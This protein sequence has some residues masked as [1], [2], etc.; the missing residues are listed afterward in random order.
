MIGSR[1]E[2]ND[3]IYLKV[4][5]DIE[6]LNENK[7]EM[8]QYN[9]IK[10]I[11]NF[12]RQYLN[13]ACFFTYNLDTYVSLKTLEKQNGLQDHQLIEILSQINEIVDS[14]EDYFL[15]ESKD[16][17]M[18]LENIYYDF[19]KEDV[20]LI[21]LPTREGTS[22]KSQYKLFLMDLISNLPI[23]R[24]HS[25]F[26]NALQRFIQVEEFSIQGLNE[27][28]KQQIL[29]DPSKDIDEKTA[30]EDLFFERSNSLAD[31]MVEKLNEKKEGSKIELIK[32]IIRGIALEVIGLLTMNLV[33]QFFEISNGHHLLAIVLGIQLLTLLAIYLIV[34]KEYYDFERIKKYLRS[35]GDYEERTVTKENIFAKNSSSLESIG[36][37]EITYNTSTVIQGMVE[38]D[39]PSK[40]YLLK[41]DLKSEEKIYITDKSFVLGRQV[42]TTDYHINDSKISKRHLEILDID[43]ELFIRDLNSTNGTYLN[44]EKLEPNRLTKIFDKDL[45]KM[46]TLVY[47]FKIE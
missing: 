19:H 43:E 21:Y 17:V 44:E 10:G 30:D 24:K 7:Y 31:P 3:S 16:L 25:A 34:L 46:A 40:A 22:F 20:H 37:E 12:N 42:E 38:E 41:K 1:I 6:A 26:M 18:S 33:I 9:K 13:D 36:E 5:I 11:I 32:D 2:M 4:P 29:G 27:L 35:K 28:I 39:Y 8:L 47:E 45:I 14:L 15:L 23:E